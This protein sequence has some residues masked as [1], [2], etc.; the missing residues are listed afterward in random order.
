LIYRF[1][2]RAL[3]VNGWGK[4]SPVTT[5]QAAR[6]PDAP[7]PVTIVGADSTSV[8]LMINACL[9]NGG[10]SLTTYTLYR[11]T[12]EFASAYTPIYSGL[13]QGEYKVINLTPG[14]KYHF[15]TTATNVIGESDFSEEV[16]WWSAS[17]PTK[18]GALSRGS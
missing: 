6:I 14:R 2:Y 16:S 11:D 12:G 5:I 18:P 17:L 8:T 1:K 7:L 13:F 4:Y 9:E 3:N 15:K 10:S